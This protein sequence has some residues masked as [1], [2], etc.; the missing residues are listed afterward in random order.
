MEY[1]NYIRLFVEQLGMVSDGVMLG[2]M[3]AIMAVL[4][5]VNTFTWR[6]SVIGLFS[7]STLS[8]YGM[9]VLTENLN[10][11]QGTSFFVVFLVGFL[12][13]EI[14]K[15]LLKFAPGLLTAAGNRAK[16]IIN[17]KDGTK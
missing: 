5:K 14:Y 13:P 12:A 15:K 8:G 6:G 1:T 9:P 16:K 17:T 3:G 2:L 4:Y 10:L 11:G 7:G